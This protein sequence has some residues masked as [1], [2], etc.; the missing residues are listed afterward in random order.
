MNPCERRNLESVAQEA[1]LSQVPDLWPEM[2]LGVCED[3]G[4]S[5]CAGAGSR[6]V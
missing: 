5:A 4:K 2:S 1:P 3:Q 6:G